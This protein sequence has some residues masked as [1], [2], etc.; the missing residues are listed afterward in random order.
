VTFNCQVIGDFD[1]EF[2]FQVDGSPTPV[3]VRLR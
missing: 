1:E 3:K 2:L